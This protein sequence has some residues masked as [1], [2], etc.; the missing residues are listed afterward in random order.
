LPGSTAATILFEEGTYFRLIYL[1]G[2]THPEDAV[3]YPSWDGHSTG[4]WEG[5][6]L[7]VD[8]VGIDDRT[9]LDG[10]GL[11]HSDRLHLI[12]RWQK[13]DA[14]TLRWTVRVEDPVFFTRPF[15]YTRDH[16]RASP[17]SKP[18]QLPDICHDRATNP[19]LRSVSGPVTG[20]P[21]RHARPP[22]FPN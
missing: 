19:S 7:V 1:D 21:A 8:T 11:Q 12:E 22:K 5:N 15:T 13:I 20:G 6:T 2:R 4:R 18:R 17:A 9:W 16:K 14:D 10:A 3:Q